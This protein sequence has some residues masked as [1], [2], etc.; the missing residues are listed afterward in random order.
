MLTAS[1]RYI[2]RKGQKYLVGNPFNEESFCS[3][4]DS[5][6]DAFRMTDF[7]EAIHIAKLIDGRVFKFNPITGTMEGGWK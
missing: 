3:L 6:Y 5:C 7:N 1:E 2:I 4:R